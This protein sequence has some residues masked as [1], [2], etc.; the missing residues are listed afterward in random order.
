M[1]I[2]VGVKKFTNDNNDKQRTLCTRVPLKDTAIRS[3][4]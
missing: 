2:K 3:I 4:N 1:R